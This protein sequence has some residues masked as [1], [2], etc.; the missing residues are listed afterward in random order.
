MTVEPIKSIK[1]FFT[2][3]EVFRM[4]ELGSDKERKGLVGIWGNQN[5]GLFESAS[6][7]LKVFKNKHFYC[8]KVN[9]DAAKEMVT[10]DEKGNILSYKFP[11]V[12]RKAHFSYEGTSTPATS[13]NFGRGCPDPEMT[14]ALGGQVH[15]KVE[16]DWQLRLLE[17]EAE[18]LTAL[19]VSFGKTSYFA[20]MFILVNA[21]EL[22]SASFLFFIQIR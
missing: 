10:Y 19:T 13:G 16:E 18:S 6:K 2:I 7:S 3:F 14:H 1:V 15:Y 8:A 4:P 22:T 12:W 11:M 17:A 9:Y 5:Y 20:C 21:N